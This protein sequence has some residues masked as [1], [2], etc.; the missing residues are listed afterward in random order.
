MICKQYIVLCYHESDALVSIYTYIYIYIII[1]CLHKSYE[2][3]TK[4]GAAARLPLGVAAAW[5]ASWDG[6]ETFSAPRGKIETA[7]FFRSKG[8][9]VFIIIVLNIYIYTWLYCL[10]ILHKALENDMVINCN[11][12][13]I[14]YL[15]ENCIVYHIS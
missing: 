7:I 11:Y 6:A 10:K 9:D 3:F 2:T 1:Q 5:C 14:S 4:C 15:M 13:D 12:V 8:M